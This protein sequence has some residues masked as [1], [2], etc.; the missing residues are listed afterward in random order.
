MEGRQRDTG[1]RPGKL[2]TRNGGCSEH[3]F[4][5]IPMLSVS[6]PSPRALRLF[7][8]LQW[9]VFDDYHEMRAG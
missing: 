6:L 9:L 4:T 7:V 5:S 1:A 3:Y 2:R 8:F